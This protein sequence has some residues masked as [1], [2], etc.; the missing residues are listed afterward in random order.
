MDDY[1]KKEEE[2]KKYLHLCVI[3]AFTFQLDMLRL[4]QV[5]GKNW[6]GF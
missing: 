4:V 3:Y 1:K 5:T 2:K 6:S